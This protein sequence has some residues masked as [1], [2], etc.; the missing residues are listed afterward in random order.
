VSVHVAK[1]A[2][3]PA[4]EVLRRDDPRWERLHDI[5]FEKSFQTGYFILASGVSSGSYSSGAK[6]QC[7]P[8]AQL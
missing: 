4:E 5:V 3:I 7:S 6:R 1:Q 2:Q 8:K